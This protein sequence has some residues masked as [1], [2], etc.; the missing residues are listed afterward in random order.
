MASSMSR[1]KK[2]RPLSAPWK[3]RKRGRPVMRPRGGRKGTSFT[4]GRLKKLFKGRRSWQEGGTAK[5]VP[6]NKRAQP[7]LPHEGKKK[8]TL[9]LF[10][11]KKK[12]HA[13]VVRK[14]KKKK[15]SL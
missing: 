7:L 9:F 6:K 15:E 13:E 14:K 10:S 3:E 1:K 11:W 2:K 8:D 5:K 4:S 12:G